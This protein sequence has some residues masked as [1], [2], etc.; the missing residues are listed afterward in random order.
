MAVELNES[1]RRVLSY[2]SR[3]V[4]RDMA[5]DRIAEFFGMKSMEVQEILKKLKFQGLIIESKGIAGVTVIITSPLKV[6]QSMLDQKVVD[7][8]AQKERGAKAGGFKR[9]TFDP[10]TGAV[11]ESSKSSKPVEKTNNNLGFDLED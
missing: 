11:V 2:C 3:G 9:K 7:M 8:L 1:E 4:S 10:N 6:K 5:V